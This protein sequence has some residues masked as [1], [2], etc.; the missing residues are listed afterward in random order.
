M[1]YR[2]TE[3]GPANTSMFCLMSAVQVGSVVHIGS[4]NITPSMVI[5]YDLAER[6]VVARHDLGPG[7]F[8]Q[9][10][11]AARDSATIYAGIVMAS[12]GEP[13][14][15]V[16]KEGAAA[17][18]PVAEVPGLD[19]RVLAVAPDGTVYAAGKEDEPAV[20]QVTGPAEAS[21]D[22]GPR[23]LAVPDPTTTQ[24]RGL[25]ADE[26][27]VWFGCGSNL[28]GGHG[29]GLTKVFRVDRV[30]GE[31]ED[32]TP[33]EV[34]SDPAVRQMCLVGRRLVVGTQGLDRHSHLA[35]IDAD[36]GRT[37]RVWELPGKSVGCFQPCPDGT[38]LLGSRNIHR[39]DPLALTLTDC[40]S[41]ESGE[42]WGLAEHGDE[43]VTISAMGD[44]VHSTGTA[45]DPDSE[46]VRLIEV[47]A[48]ALPQLGMSL[49]VNGS[50]LYVGGNGGVVV[51]DLTG[52]WGPEMTHKR[53]EIP[54][55]AKTITAVDGDTHF[56]VYSSQGIWTHRADGWLGRTV[57]VPPEFNRPQ[58]SCWDP[59][60]QRLLVGYQN[61]TQGGGALLVADPSSGTADLL[62][63]P[64]D[65]RQMVRAVT[66]RD[67]RAYLG[68][69][70]RYPQGDRG[71][72]VCLDPITGEVAWRH[73]GS[74][75]G[76][77]C[78]GLFGD[79][80][81]AITMAGEA[82][83]L[84]AATGELLN[85]RDL[86]HLLDGM[87]RIVEFGERPSSLDSVKRPSSEVETASEV[88]PAQ[89]SPGFVS[90]GFGGVVPPAQQGIVVGSADTVLRLTTP[91]L[92]PEVIVTGLDGQWYS[93]PKIAA[94]PDGALYTLAGRS[95][96]RISADLGEER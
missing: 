50:R 79:H 91:E 61:D 74:S 89:P 37:I 63:N 56:A 22:G 69:W 43:V 96:V 41:P 42:R 19:V 86:S 45:N 21:L 8:V 39:L 84:D 33:P 2:V 15:F 28:A 82:L 54:G 67:G 32:L 18:E 88:L 1:R 59:T 70:N 25:A 73:P 30:T 60:R 93:G 92:E 29:A 11:A 38:V 49:Q 26:T 62:V 16:V 81:Y 80:L 23:R 46:R 7:R 47:G 17:G 57:D 58:D 34:A 64:I 68:G 31:V 87:T 12:P 77:S 71:S 24:C 4:R 27:S 78:L 72:I 3:L 55:E 48:P 36:T 76:V 44:V 90:G 5:S 94:G 10:L 35:V 13:N 6:R 14:V 95:V 51:H 83:A 20:W 9:A 53:L 65:E 52:A 40:P 75:A 66:T 85:R